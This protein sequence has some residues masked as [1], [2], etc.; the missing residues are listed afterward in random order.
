M[1]YVQIFIKQHICLYLLVVLII[2]INIILNNW[3]ILGLFLQPFCS[4]QN[5]SEACTLLF[6]ALIFK[7]R[8]LCRVLNWFRT[9][10]NNRQNRPIMF[11]LDLLNYFI[12]YYY[13]WW[14]SIF[15]SSP[16]LGQPKMVTKKKVMEARLKKIS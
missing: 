11:L 3:T 15:T 16:V 9:S 8:L 13:S 14:N 6:S 12:N 10:Q 4:V 5:Q 7:V 1:L 2:L